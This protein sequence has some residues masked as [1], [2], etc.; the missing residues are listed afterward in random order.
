MSEVTKIVDRIHLIDAFSQHYAN[1]KILGARPML[2]TS[3]G[4]IYPKIELGSI[5]NSG[6]TL[7]PARPTM[8]HLGFVLYK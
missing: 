4:T 1:P 7:V 8:A 2:Q 6:N 3:A 5:R